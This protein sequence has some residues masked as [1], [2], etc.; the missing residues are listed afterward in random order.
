MPHLLS[1]YAVGSGVA[2]VPLPPMPSF[3]TGT[4][5][6]F[7]VAQVQLLVPQV[8]L[9]TRPVSLPRPATDTPTDDLLRRAQEWQMLE[10]GAEGDEE[11]NEVEVDY[12]Y[13]TQAA[14]EAAAL[15]LVSLP[16]VAVE[17]LQEIP[18]GFSCDL[19]IEHEDEE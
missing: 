5:T 17:A 14:D 7:M 3:F 10:G 9:P 12:S 6:V 15:P 18:S 19:G 2:S 8:S 13:M 4:A 16:E 11:P 1:E